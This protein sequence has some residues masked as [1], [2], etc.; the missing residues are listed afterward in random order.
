MRPASSCC[1]RITRKSTCRRSRSG[2]RASSG[3]PPRAA[4]RPSSTAAGSVELE[5]V[6][7]GQ[8]RSGARRRAARSRSAATSRSGAIDVHARNVDIAAA[9][10]AAPAEPRLLGQADRRRE[11]HRLAPRRPSIEG[12]IAVDNGGVPV[13][14]LRVA[15]RDRGLPRHADRHRRH[16]A[17]VADRVDHGEGQRADDAVQ[18]AARAASTWSPRRESRSTCRSRPPRS[19]SALVQGFTDVVTNVTG[20]LQT[21]VHVTGSAQDP[22]LDGFIDIKNGGFGVPDAGGTFTGLTTRIDLQPDRRA[23]S[24]VP[25]A[26]SPR[27]EA[28][29]RRRARDARGPGRRGQHHDRLRQ[30]RAHRQRARRRPGA[31]GAEGHRRA[32]PA[33]RRGRACGLDAGR[34]E[35][36]QIL[37][38]FYD[39]YATEALPDVCRPERTIERSGS[40][41]EATKRGARERREQSRRRRRR[42]LRRDAAPVAPQRRSSKRSSSTST[43]SLP[44]NLVLRGN[45]LRPGGPT[46]DRARRH[47]H[48]RRRRPAD[49]QERRTGR[50]RRIGTVDDRARHLRVPGP[51]VRPRARRHDPVHRHAD[52][53]PAA[54]HHGDADDS[55]HRR[56]A[57]KVHITGTPRAPQLALSSDPPLEESDILSLIVFNRPVNELGTGER[58]VARGDGR[59][60]RDRLHRR[61]ARRVDRQGARP[62]SLRDHDDRPTTGELGAGVTLGQQLGDTRVRAASGSSSASAASPSS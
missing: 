61:A 53:Q 9:R 60:H 54:R 33:A 10:D 26:G 1:T 20:T 36:D 17:A 58:V 23:D 13:L 5:N 16:A 44:D 15:R 52:D 19:A 42:V 4:T 25:A 3:A 18:R 22:H 12:H 34:I 49:P 57:R 35:V 31:D 48:H 62:R 46:G 55:E 45:E 38:L 24:A 2:R 40:A 43:S 51:A 7:P 56:H 37:Q 29:D 41:E 59:R 21:D 14:S 39:P 30:L 47:E 11:D 50:S 27:G 6:Q 32:P 8:R 28:D